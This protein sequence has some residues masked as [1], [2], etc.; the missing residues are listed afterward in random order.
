[1]KPKQTK[2]KSQILVKDFQRRSRECQEYVRSTFL[3]EQIRHK[4]LRQALEHYFSYWNDF[5]HP[6][7]FSVAFEA[8]GGKPE[9]LEKPQAAMAMIAAA[10]DIHDDIIDH[11][12]RKHDHVTV[13][14]KF[15]Q[16]ISILLGDA[17][18]TKGLT[19]LSTSASEYAGD[20]EK[21]VFS[22]IKERLFEVGNAHAQELEMKRRLDVLPGEYLRVLEMKAASIEADMHVA[23]LMARGNE[24]ETAT[25]KDYGRIIGFLATLREEFVDIFEP[26]E[27]NC[28]LKNE[29][30]P[31]PLMFALEDDE[32][33]KRIIRMIKERKITSKETNHLADLV[34]DMEPVIALRKKMEKLRDQAISLA[35]ELANRKSKVLL[36]SLAQSMLEDL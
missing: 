27:L 1:M 31:V 12:K 34:L 28:R 17:F 9:N 36:T 13:F 26:E 5:T 21:E 16:D 35:R 20:K 33:K 23:S 6:G 14:G 4:G 2:S 15:G 8:A 7:L 3:S 18:L 24:K 22:T 30:L 25:L 10:F 19:L 29:T 11:S 32:M